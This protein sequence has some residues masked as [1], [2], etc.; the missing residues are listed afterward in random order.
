MVPPPV[1]TD[2]TARQA[3]AP[4]RDAGSGRS[5]LELGWIDAVR[6]EGSRA[7]FRLALPGFATSQRDRIA[8]EARAALLSVAGI[9]DLQIEL[10]QPA[11]PPPSAGPIGGAG[12]GSGGHGQV[13]ERQPIPGVRS[14]TPSMVGALGP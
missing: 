9:D 12:H 14:A 2:D 6:V 8:A 4:L 11:A 1:A 13:P 10:A 3:L 7:V 5:M